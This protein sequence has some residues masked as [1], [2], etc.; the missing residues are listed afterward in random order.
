MTEPTKANPARNITKY[1]N[2]KL[3][4]IS[5]LVCQGYFAVLGTLNC[6]LSTLFKQQIQEYDLCK[7]KRVINVIYGKGNVKYIINNYLKPIGSRVIIK[8]AIFI[9]STQLINGVNAYV[10]LICELHV[11]QTYVLS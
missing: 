9:T 7:I 3:A 4:I 11:D 8:T 10:K 5:H 2:Q 1:P 6:P